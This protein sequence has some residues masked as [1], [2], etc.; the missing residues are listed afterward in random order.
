MEIAEQL[1]QLRV[2]ESGNKIRVVETQYQS[3]G[4]DLP[5]HI[6]QVE[7]ILKAEVVNGTSISSDSLR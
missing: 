5:E 4:V 1:E 7:Q 2:V 3:V 6:G